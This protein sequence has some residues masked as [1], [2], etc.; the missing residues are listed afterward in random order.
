MNIQHHYNFENIVRFDKLSRKVYKCEGIAEIEIKE[1][2]HDEAP[3]VMSFILENPKVDCTIVRAFEGNL[4][5]SRKVCVIDGKKKKYHNAKATEYDFDKNLFFKYAFKN[6]TDHK[7]SKSDIVSLVRKCAEDCIIVD[8]YVYEKD[9]EPIYQIDSYGDDYC[10]GLSVS[11]LWRDDILL[12]PTYTFFSALERDELIKEMERLLP[13]YII[14]RN[15][16]KMAYIKVWDKRYVKFRHQ[17]QDEP[18]P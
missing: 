15:P 3:M 2:S 9:K 7:L 11:K 1:V 16:I 14:K 4:Y 5:W 13:S 6:M 17:K 12:Y 8:G 10:L 18:K